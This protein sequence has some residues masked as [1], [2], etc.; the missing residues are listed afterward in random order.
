VAV[1]AT[2]LRV[3]I[4]Q[5]VRDAGRAVGWSQRDLAIKCEL[6]QSTICRIERAEFLGLNLSTAA[7][8]L[9]VLDIRASFDFKTPYLADRGKQTDLGHARCV[10]YVA[11]RLR[12][13]GWLV[14]TEVEI[15]SGSARGWIDVLA[16]READS[17]LLVIEVKTEL[18]D[19]GALQRQIAWYEREAWK[20]ARRESWPAGRLLSAVVLLESRTNT[21]RVL[22]NGGL[23]KAEFPLPVRDFAAVVTGSP[24]PSGGRCLAF[25]DPLNRR[26]TWLRRAPGSNAQV[27]PYANYADFVSRSRGR[28]A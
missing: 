24:P 15:V 6:N 11:R 19:I 26:R 7:G 2:A 9:D 21:D 8:V 28:R 10:D 23:L 13:N 17:V 14:R 16:F 22:A 18:V 1:T 20:V 12:R 27:P 5:T 25:I 3:Q 4:A